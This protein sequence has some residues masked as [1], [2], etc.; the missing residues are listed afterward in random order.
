[1]VMDSGEFAQTVQANSLEY[2][3]RLKEMV[4]D[5][6]TSVGEEELIRMTSWHMWAEYNLGVIPPARQIDLLP[7]EDLDLKLLLTD[8]LMEEHHHYKVF[9]RIVDYLGGDSDIT[10]FKP[11][12]AQRA[13]Y[14]ATLDYETAWEIA[15]SL[16]LTGEVILINILQR[17]ARLLPN[18]MGKFL[19]DEVILH[20]GNHVDTGRL[21]VQRYATTQAIQDRVVEISESKFRQQCETYGLDFYAQIKGAA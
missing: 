6:V 4:L 10:R 9:S 16:Q 20:E 11:N 12:S 8:Q 14:E 13:L 17:L 5:P 15:A 18:K 3:G 19:E 2:A 7:F 21:I 1:M